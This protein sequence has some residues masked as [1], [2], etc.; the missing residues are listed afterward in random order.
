LEPPTGSKERVKTIAVRRGDHRLHCT[1]GF[2]KCAQTRSKNSNVVYHQDVAGAQLRGDV[3]KNTRRTTNSVKPA[4][5]AL[6]RWLPS[7]LG[8]G[9]S[10]VPRVKERAEVVRHGGDLPGTRR[11]GEPHFGLLRRNPPVRALTRI[12]HPAR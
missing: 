3:R 7:D 5:I 2:A 9:E 4:L 8:V 1:A 10:E 6:S 11:V 12:H